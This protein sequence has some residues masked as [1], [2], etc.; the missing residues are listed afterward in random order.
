MHDTKIIPAL[1]VKGKVVVEEGL[2]LGF[3]THTAGTQ[4][5][6]EVEM[7]NGGGDTNKPCVAFPF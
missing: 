7:G 4:T 2:V 3:F 1:K 5:V 6:N